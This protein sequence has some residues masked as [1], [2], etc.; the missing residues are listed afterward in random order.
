MVGKQTMTMSVAQER[1]GVESVLE[2]FCVTV[3]TQC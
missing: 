2:E 1:K 3:A